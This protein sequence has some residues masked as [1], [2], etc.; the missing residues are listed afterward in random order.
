[1]DH[2]TIG[3]NN[4]VIGGAIRFGGGKGNSNYFTNDTHFGK[5]GYSFRFGEGEGYAKGNYDYNEGTVL[6]G[7]HGKGQSMEEFTE[8]FKKRQ[9]SKTNKRSYGR[10]DIC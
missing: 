9:N 2:H 8:K 1:M 10:D 3:N 7:G 4:W 5:K 6:K